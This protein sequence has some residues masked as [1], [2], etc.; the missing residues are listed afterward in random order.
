MRGSTVRRIV[1][2]LQ[3]P[4]ASRS[5][6]EWVKHVCEAHNEAKRTKESFS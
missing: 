6:I 5:S 1:E 4:C 2:A 3:D